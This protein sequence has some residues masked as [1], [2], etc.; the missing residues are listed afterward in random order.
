MSIN[1]VISLST[2]TYNQSGTYT[3]YTIKANPDSEI[4]KKEKVGDLNGY[5]MEEIIQKV[6]YKQYESDYL[7]ALIEV[8]EFFSNPNYIQERV[9]AYAASLLLEGFIGNVDIAISEY[10]QNLKK[11]IK[12]K[13]LFVTAPYQPKSF[14]YIVRKYHLPELLKCDIYQL[15]DYWYDGIDFIITYDP[16]IQ[17]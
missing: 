6:L 17:T 3:L 15:Y 10:T 2:S 1:Q 9:G 4:A 8:K 7:I 11:K 13:I 16:L 12:N 14:D 5:E